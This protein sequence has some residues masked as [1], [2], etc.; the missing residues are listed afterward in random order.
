[1]RIPKNNSRWKKSALSVKLEISFKIFALRAHS[2]D[3]YGLGHTELL[4]TA[5]NLILFKFNYFNL[6]FD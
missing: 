6:N 2:T 1:M 3:R 5:N 4:G